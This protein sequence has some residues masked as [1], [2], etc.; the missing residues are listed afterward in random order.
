VGNVQHVGWVDKNFT[1]A[2]V[3]CRNGQPDCRSITAVVTAVMLVLKCFEIED[4]PVVLV[5]P[6]ALLSVVG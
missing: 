3:W 5:V 4:V 2:I 6:S 1:S